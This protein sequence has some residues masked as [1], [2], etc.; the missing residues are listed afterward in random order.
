MMKK[1][2]LIRNGIENIPKRS[3]LKAITICS[4]SRLQEVCIVTETTGIGRYYMI[5]MVIGE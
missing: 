3:Y 5:L 4:K 2:R 1:K